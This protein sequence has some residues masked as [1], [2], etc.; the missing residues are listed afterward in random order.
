MELL[1]TNILPLNFCGTKDQFVS[2]FRL[3]IFNYRKIVL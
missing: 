3:I 1:S 2:T